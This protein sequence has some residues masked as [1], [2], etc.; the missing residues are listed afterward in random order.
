MNNVHNDLY[1]LEP[2]PDEPI[3]TRLEREERLRDERR[4]E[5]LENDDDKS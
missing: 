5:L 3:E 4:D 2:E 1:Y